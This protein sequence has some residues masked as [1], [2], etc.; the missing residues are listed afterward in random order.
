MVCLADPFQREAED[1]S[2]HARAAGCDDGFGQVSARIGKRA[3][4]GRGVVDVG[5]S[6]LLQDERAVKDIDYR[7]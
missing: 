4:A 1:S 3:S 5:E 6:D 2:R 7:A